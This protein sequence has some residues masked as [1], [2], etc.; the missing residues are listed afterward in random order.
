MR[1]AELV[2]VERVGEVL[3]VPL[4]SERNLEAQRLVW[5]NV[6]DQYYLIGGC[7]AN[8]TCFRSP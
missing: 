7:T 4:G 1:A 3:T 8:E 6:R 2:G 5:W